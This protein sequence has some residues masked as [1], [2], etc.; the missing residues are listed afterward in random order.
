MRCLRIYA[1]PDGEFHF[2]EVDIPATIAPLFPNDDAV[3]AFGPSFRR[4]CSGRKGRRVG[5]ERHHVVE[6]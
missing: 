5:G 4:G 1:S 3:R 2:G 6:R